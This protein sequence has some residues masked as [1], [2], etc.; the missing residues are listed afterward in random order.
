MYIGIDEIKSKVY[1][2]QFQIN[3]SKE[4]K[5]WELMVGE[6]ESYIPQPRTVRVRPLSLLCCAIVMIEVLVTGSTIGM[7]KN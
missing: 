2:R 4:Y 7:L 3:A 5:N 1:T 6:R